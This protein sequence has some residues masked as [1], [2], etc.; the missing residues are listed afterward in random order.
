MR[1]MEKGAHSCDISIQAAEISSRFGKGGRVREREKE[2]EH[3]QGSLVTVGTKFTK[4]VQGQE[5]S[6]VPLSLS[7]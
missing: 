6:W 3:D 2:R 4:F 5:I 1:E 7:C